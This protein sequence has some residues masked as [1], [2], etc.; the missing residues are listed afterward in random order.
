MAL[1]RLGS[2]AIADGV[3]ATADIADGS[4]STVKLAN[5]AVTTAKVADTVN[6]GRRNL[7]IN[8]AMNVAQ[9]GTSETGVTSPGYYTCDRFEYNQSGRD[10]AIVTVSQTSDAPDGFTKSFKIETTTAETTIDS[11][12]Y[13]MARYR[14]EA[15]DLQHL[16]YGSSSAKQL[17]LSFWVKSSIAATYAAYLYSHDGIRIIGSTYTIDTASTWEYK[18]IT[19]A[20]DTGGTINDDTGIGLDVAFVLAAG[21]DMITT[22]NTSWS[23]YAAGKL[24]YGHTTAA[25]A[26]MTTANATWQITGVQLEVGDTATPFEHRSYGEEL[27]LCERYYQKSYDT[28]YYAGDVTYDGAISQ[29]THGNVSSNFLTSALPTRMRGMPTVTFYGTSSATNTAGNIRGSGDAVI[30]ANTGPSVSEARIDLS[31]TSNQTYS[32]ITAHYTADAEL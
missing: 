19:F 7:V 2:N 31:F 15:Q 9:R 10:E 16:K 11:T 32:Y 17:T 20:G 5:D 21:S 13:F 3:V 8:G 30:S 6:L 23:A 22:D 29:R 26:V 28:N 12:E 18:T 25:N 24:A 1:D 14:I 27:S 4:I